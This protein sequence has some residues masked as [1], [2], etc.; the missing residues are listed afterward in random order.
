LIANFY[1][2]KEF[3]CKQCRNLTKKAK[4]LFM[5]I[6]LAIIGCGNPMRSDDGC[7]Q[8][9]IQKLQGMRK[10]NLPE[11]VRLIDAGTGG[12]EV[13]YDVRDAESVIF[14]DACDMKSPSGSLFFLQGTD[15]RIPVPSV[16]MHAFRWDHAL[17]VGKE[18][19]GQTFLDKTCAYLIAVES[20]NFG[21]SLR[22][23]VQDSADRL[24]QILDQRISGF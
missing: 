5:A 14:I 12:L 2:V 8:Y 21:M 20:I 1:P 11:C 16:N 17:G 23:S 13:I 18:L 15:I 24:V 4:S 6:S 9:V 10:S 3:H 22:K 19:W 7:G